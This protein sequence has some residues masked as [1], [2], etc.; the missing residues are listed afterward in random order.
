MIWIFSVAGAD[1]GT[2]VLGSLSAGGTLNPSRAIKLTL[3]EIMAG[4]AAIVLLAGSGGTDA[5]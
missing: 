5:I 1:A 2:I 4:M 3:G